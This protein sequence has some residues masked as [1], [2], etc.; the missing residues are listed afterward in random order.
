[1]GVYFHLACRKCGQYLHFGK[2]LH[3]EDRDT[4]QGLYSEQ[5]NKWISDERAWDATQAF[6][7]EHVGHPLFFDDDEQ[8]RSIDEYDEVGFDRFLKHG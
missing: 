5:S 3:K 1:M 2:K 6:L 8:G 4:L 7:L